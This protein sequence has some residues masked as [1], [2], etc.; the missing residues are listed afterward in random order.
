M[1]QRCLN[2]N[3]KNYHRYGGRGIAICD[4]WDDFLTFAHDVGERPEGLTL[5]R[6]DPDGNYEPENCRWATPKQQRANQS[7]DARRAHG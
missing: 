3:A 2:P 1:R 4:R 7:S 5:D 6:V